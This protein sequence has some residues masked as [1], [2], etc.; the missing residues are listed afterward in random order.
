MAAAPLL[1][2]AA[3]RRQFLAVG[4]QRSAFVQTGAVEPEHFVVGAGLQ[5]AGRLRV[6]GVALP[7]ADVIELEDDR[8]V[9]V[10]E[11]DI[12]AAAVAI[13]VAFEIDAGGPASP[14]P[15]AGYRNCPDP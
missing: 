3:H 12:D 15:V 14:G 2:L 7:D 9:A 11:R 1:T 4:D 8:I 6:G 13:D 5:C 10:G